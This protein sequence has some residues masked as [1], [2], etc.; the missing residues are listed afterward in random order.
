MG[1]WF[2]PRGVPSHGTWLGFACFFLMG[3]VSVGQEVRP[4]EAVGPRVMGAE[5]ALAQLEALRPSEEELY[6]EAL[7]L[8]RAGDPGRALGLYFEIFKLYPEGARTEEILFR[9]AQGYQELGRFDE[10]RKALENLR[11]RAPDGPWLGEAALVEGTMLMAEEKFAEAREPLRKA[12]EKLDGALRDRARFLLAHASERLGRLSE[13]KEALVALAR[14]REPG[15]MRDYGR[16]RLGM[17]LEA[18]GKVDEAKG[19]YQQVF[20]EGHQD[21]VK[22]EAAV[23]A[24][25][26]AFKR[27]DYP[28]ALGYFESARRGGADPHW[29]R[30]AHGG[31]IFTQFAAGKYG[32]VI[33]IFNEV[34]PEFPEA[35]RAEIFLLAAESLRLT[36]KAEEAKA[37][38]GFILQE[39]PKSPQAEP[40]AWG[41]VLIMA[42]EKNKDLLPETARYL[43]RFPEGAR[44]FEVKL[45]R[46]DGLFEKGEWKAATGMY[47]EIAKDK[48]FATLAPE[49][50]AAL[51][52]RVAQGAFEL[53]DY[54]GAAEAGQMFLE[55]NPKDS[56]VPDVLW[57]MG[58][59]QQLA[60]EPELALKSWQRLVR[61]F[62]KFAGAETARWKTAVLAGSLKKF[63]VMEKELKGLLEHFPETKFAAEAHA[64]LG[65]CARELGRPQEGRV[66][67]ERARELDPKTYYGQATQN[68]LELALSREDVEG[69]RDE[70]GRYESW[71]KSQPKAP[72]VQP[73]VVAWVA[74][75]L[76]EKGRKEEA[77]EWFRRAVREAKEGEQRHRNQLALCLLLNELERWKEAVTEWQSFRVNFP[78][79]A[80]RSVVLV[81]LA[82]ASIGAGDL[83][84]A[85]KLTEQILRQNPE[86]EFNARGR[87]LLGD[88]A[89]A[90]NQPEEAAKLYGAVALLIDHPELTPQALRKAR[91]AWEQAGNRAKV[92]EMGEALAVWERGKR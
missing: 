83:A 72:P 4:A 27:G 37:Q 16:L 64:W 74:F 85:R 60:G 8:H 29:K 6:Q 31:L 25:N 49:R 82:Q 91:S 59:A 1:K 36:G 19:W 71:R 3:G 17:V 35:T 81:P 11:G 76:A 67:W 30:L 21:Q 33:T 88:L 69:V 5:E 57:M 89:L 79:D 70:I 22:A 56:A 53:K 41:R 12:E 38:Y 87:L 39:F 75:G 54:A 55:K 44:V 18:E 86:G 48:A 15:P 14:L 24:G 34:R 9:V 52:L 77:V 50:Q 47:R 73:E 2:Q 62:P 84:G 90:E 65:Q 23:R 63:E 68:L 13:A 66:H 46:A 45:I 28:L 20:A 43:A 51:Y 58:Q 42:G 78:D 61:E 92:K 7:A 80:N 10:A 32:E 40:A 26:L